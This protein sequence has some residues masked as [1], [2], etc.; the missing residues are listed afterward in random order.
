MPDSK[1]VLDLVDQVGIP[2]IGTSANFHG[3]KAPKSFDK[4]DPELVKLVDFV[5]R[6]KCKEGI[7]STVVDATS[8]PPKILRHGAVI[9]N[10]LTQLT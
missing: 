7:E 8:D 4:L 3:Q 1:L 5:I 10:Q 6:G 9:I 2:I